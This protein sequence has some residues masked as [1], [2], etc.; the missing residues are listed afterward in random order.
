[1]VQLFDPAEAGSEAV[2]YQETRHFRLELVGAYGPG[3]EPPAVP[4]I[5]PEPGW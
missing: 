1:M 2:F 3:L 4:W 5:S